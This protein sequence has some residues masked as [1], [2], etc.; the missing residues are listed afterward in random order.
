MISNENEIHIVASGID[1]YC[2]HNAVVPLS[3]LKEN[4]KN[5]N[6]HP[7]SQIELLAKIIKAQGWRNPIVVSTR[8]GYITKGH[9]RLMAAKKLG[10]ATVPIDKQWYSSDEAEMEDML[11]DNRISELSDLSIPEVKDLIAELEKAG[12]DMDLTGYDKAALEILKNAFVPDESMTPSELPDSGLQG[13]SPTSN[14]FIL[15]Y[16]DEDEK[17]FWMEKLGLKKD[18]IVWS[19]SELKDVPTV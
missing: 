17:R 3:D 13:L 11:A 5:P 9:A 7:E 8:S 1:I 4:P 6:K 16:D 14:K 10:L 19:V 12:A 18:K 15:I 2:S